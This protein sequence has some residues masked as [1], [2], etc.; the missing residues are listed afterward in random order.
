MGLVQYTESEL[1]R[2]PKDE[3]GMQDLVNRN[4]LEIVKA[5]SKLGFPVTSLKTL[6]ISPSVLKICMKE[7]ARSSMKLNAIIG[8]NE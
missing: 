5:F 7:S 8:G 6:P 2:I 3:Y 1:S 4:I